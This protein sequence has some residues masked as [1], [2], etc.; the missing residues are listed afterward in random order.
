MP[1]D[2]PAPAGGGTWAASADDLQRALD[3]PVCV[4]LDELGTLEVVGADAASFLHSQL[5]NDVLHLDERHVQR[6]GYCTAKG[7]LL[8]TFEAWRQADAIRLELPREILPA[9]AKRLSMFVLRAKARVAD[10]SGQWATLALVGPGAATALR[11]AGAEVPE[12]GE[13]RALGAVL[14]TGA[15]AGSRLHERYLLRG[16]QAEVGEWRRRL[17][18]PTVAAGVWWWSQIDAG[19]PT[20][21]AATQEKFVPQMINYEVLAGVSF[22]KGCYPGQ[23]VVARSQ[24]LGKLRRRM[25][26][27]HVDGTAQAAADVY[28]EGAA[29][30]VGQVVMAAAAPG[31]GMDVL[32]ECPLDRAGERPLRVGRAD[33]PLLHTR[34]LPY[35]L[36][37]VTA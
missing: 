29:E 36:V 11:A 3:Q 26:L 9:I 13:T 5:T 18:L 33:G 16:P 25:G 15:P 23:E 21:F 7:R 31:G 14:L 17:D 34:P 37:D 2:L 12:A 1:D 35:A 20:V 19:L 8:A 6:N 10:A 32:F 28:A 27:G 30:P 24:Y 22:K 4:P